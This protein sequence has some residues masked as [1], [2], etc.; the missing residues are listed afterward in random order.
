MAFVTVLPARPGVPQASL[1]GGQRLSLGMEGGK[2][3][4]SH[5][6]LGS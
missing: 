3:T 4:L 2:Q 5:E 1:W 6:E